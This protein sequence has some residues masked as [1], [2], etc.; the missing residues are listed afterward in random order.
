LFGDICHRNKRKPTQKSYLIKAKEISNS[1][2]LI[3][4]NSKKWGNNKN[5]TFLHIKPL[6]ND[7]SL[8]CLENFVLGL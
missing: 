7:F 4:S 5:Q 3:K 6:N 8:F 1:K 2:E